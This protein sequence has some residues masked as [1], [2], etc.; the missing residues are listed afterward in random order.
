MIRLKMRKYNMILTEKQQK[1][2]HYDQV[3]YEF[4]TGKEILS[5]DQKRIIEQKNWRSRGKTNKSTWRAWITV[6]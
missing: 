5:S 2:W 1:H 3:K 4:L 6:S